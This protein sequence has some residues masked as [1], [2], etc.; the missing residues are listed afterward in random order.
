V[1]QDYSYRPP[2]FDLTL[3]PDSATAEFESPSARSSADHPRYEDLGQLGVGG[4]AEVRRVRDRELDRVV[5]MKV[6]K[7]DQASSPAALARFVDEARLSARLRHPAIVPVFDLGRR[8]DGRLYFTMELVDGRT[9]GE[10]VLDWH[11]DA[12]AGTLDGSSLPRWRP[13]VELYA[14]ICEAVAHAHDQGIVH[15]DL[16]PA[17]VMVGPHGAVRVVDWGLALL[18]GSPPAGVVG[19]PHYMA[20]EQAA[21]D[22]DLI[23]PATDVWALGAILVE[24]FTALPPWR[25]TD[26]AEILRLLAQGEVPM[27]TPSSPRPPEPLWALAREC[28]R[29]DPQARPGDA[30]AV[31]DAVRE[32]LDGVAQRARGR[33]LVVQAVTITPRVEA[34]RH[35]I[36]ELREQADAHARA[37]DPRAPIADK[38]PGWVLEDQ[39]AAMARDAHLAEAEHLQLLRGALSVAP[40]L[41][42]AHAAL[43]D[44]F[45]ARHGEAEDRGDIDE[46]AHLEVFL[47]EHDRAGAHAAYLDGAGHL[48]LDADAEGATATLS[49]YALVDRRL[50]AVE[51]EPLPLPADR[52]LAAGSWL[53][54]VRAPGREPARVPVFVDRCRSWRGTVRLLSRVP[55]GACYVPAG[56]TWVGGDPEVP[57]W[58]RRRVWVDGFVIG[59]FPVTNA[60]FIAFLDALVADGRE[61]EALRHVP[62][63]RAGSA[64]DEGPMI[65]GR[66]G[67]G[68]FVLRPDADGDVWLPDAPVLMIDWDGATAYAA[69][70]AVQD[71]LP[72]RLPAE[73]EWEKAARGADGRRYPWGDHPDAT[74][75]CIR[76]SHTGSA[77]PP[78]VGAYPLDDSPYGVRGLAG[79]VRDWCADVGSVGEAGPS[80]DGDRAVVPPPDSPG[81]PLWTGRSGPPDAPRSYRGGDWY[82]LA[83]HARA[84]YRAWNK[85]ATRNY[86]LG[87]RIACSVGDQQASPHPLSSNP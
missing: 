43:A 35:R 76:P 61:D 51:P 48:V 32:W 69:W 38:R 8:P 71:G 74:W 73:V 87:F 15:R 42:E 24:L 58:P 10:H 79:G 2:S 31:A 65:Y 68:R 26:R 7:D 57:S 4:L 84:A 72:W 50:V 1:P 22:H 18:L 25:R 13:L 29:A 44:W 81:S 46:A 28:L 6:I 63:E 83:V 53:V 41:P 45:R 86:S 39:A 49:R 34:L 17:N 52:P 78:V 67:D 21:R 85:P 23:G 64:Q 3:P 14:R 27:I 59:R 75:M 70:R 12:R 19:T 9:F 20:P 66:G 55:P 54:E 30:G 56:W 36:A 60:E 40:D 62:R 37:T 80:L 11:R 5:A 82:G 16:K 47:R 77:A 33:E